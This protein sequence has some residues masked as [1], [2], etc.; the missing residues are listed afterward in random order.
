MRTWHEASLDHFVE[1][2]EEMAVGEIIENIALNEDARSFLCLVPIAAHLSRGA[3][4]WLA[5]PQAHQ[6]AKP[7]SGL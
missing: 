2:K 4:R 7:R 1:E 5:Q 6:A 3:S